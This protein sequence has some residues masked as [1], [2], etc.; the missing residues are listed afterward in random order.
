MEV[1]YLATGGGMTAEAATIFGALE[2][3]RPESELPLVGQAV[4]QLNAGQPQE[5]I[6]LLRK[7]L[8]RNPDSEFAATF[9]GLS[10]MQA[11]M[12]SAAENILKQ[13]EGSGRNP[14]AV[15]LAKNLLGGE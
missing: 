11:G 8:E 10:L 4:T 6:A 13:V 5:A 1:G 15:G 2:A 3:V 12:T 7:A 9:L 14:Q